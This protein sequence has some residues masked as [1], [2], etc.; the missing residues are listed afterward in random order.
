MNKTISL[1]EQYIKQLEQEKARTGFTASD[2]I[3][4]ALDLYFAKRGA[5]GG[6]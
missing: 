5:G 4:R 2:T 1:P 6:V 3:R